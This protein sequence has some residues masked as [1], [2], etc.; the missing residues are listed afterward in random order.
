MSNKFNEKTPSKSVDKFFTAAGIYRNPVSATD[1]N[2]ARYCSRAAGRRKKNHGKEL[3][4]RLC[5]FSA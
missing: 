3:S 5:L 4:L 1:F 2:F